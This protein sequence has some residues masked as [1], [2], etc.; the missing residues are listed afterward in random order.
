M[1]QAINEVKEMA[2]YAIVTDLAAGFRKGGFILH[3]LV[4]LFGTDPKR[5]TTVVDYF[6]RISSHSLTEGFVVIGDDLGNGSQT[7]THQTSNPFELWIDHRY[8]CV[9]IFNELEPCDLARISGASS[10]AVY[11]TRIQ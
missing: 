8:K 9:S 6:R 10:T 4:S 7:N 2:K 1:E 5:H 11:N 3:L